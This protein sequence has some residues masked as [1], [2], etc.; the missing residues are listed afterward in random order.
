[1]ISSDSSLVFTIENFSNQNYW[2]NCLKCE[3]PWE[4]DTYKELDISDFQL[5]CFFKILQPSKTIKSIVEYVKR[6]LGDKFV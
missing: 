5:L 3:H 4:I 1:M 2:L 6:G